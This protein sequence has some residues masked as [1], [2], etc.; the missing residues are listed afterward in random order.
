[1]ALRSE[2]ISTDINCQGKQ[3][4]H[5]DSYWVCSVTVPTTASLP[6]SMYNSGYFWTIN[7]N[8]RYFCKDVSDNQ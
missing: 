8:G 1:M 5:Y 2:A 4:A 6:S 7:D 3:L